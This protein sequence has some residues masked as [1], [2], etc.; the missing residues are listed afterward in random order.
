VKELGTDVGSTTTAALTGTPLYLSPEA[1]KD[2]KR[3][4]GRSDLYAVGAVIFY[5]LTGTH[6][7]EATTIVEVCSHHLHT[8]PETPSERLGRSVPRD[9]ERVVMR[10]L[11]KPVDDRF[12]DAQS[13]R[14][15]L[16]AC[17]CAEEWTDELAVEWWRTNRDR[18]ALARPAF[19]RPSRSAGP[20]EVDLHGRGLSGRPG[21]SAKTVETA[22]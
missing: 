7:F 2:P 15:A 5:L 8:Q 16:E 13:L 17:D 6:V 22:S 18:A 3:V 20:L 4:D 9:L 1:I 14:D 19:D 12:R 11:A 10:C 21:A